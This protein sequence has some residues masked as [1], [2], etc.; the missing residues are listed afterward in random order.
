MA[1]SGI[2]IYKLLPKTNCKDC[3]FPTCMAFAL[4]L[5]TKQVELAACPHVSEEAQEELAASAVPP[6]RL[7]KVKSNGHE[8]QVGNEKNVKY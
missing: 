3:G 2:E 6:V 8:V 4:K 7:I 5:A 1:L